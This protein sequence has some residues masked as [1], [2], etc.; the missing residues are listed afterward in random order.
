MVFNVEKCKVM[1]FGRNNAEFNYY[2][3]GKALE[4]VTEEKDLG[5]FLSDDLKSS[6]QCMYAYS[7]ASRMLDMVSRAITWK[8]P[9]I[10]LPFYKTLVRPHLEYCT[11]AWSPYYKKDKAL[12]ERVQ[13]RFTRMIPGLRDKVYR[14]RL[15][16]LGLWSLEERRNRTD[17][18]EV[19]KIWKGMSS[20]P[21]A[22]LFELNTGGNTRGHSAKLRKHHCRLDLRQRFFSERVISRWNRLDQQTIDSTSV[23]VFKNNLTRL[24]SSQMG[25]FMDD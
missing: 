5:I 7:R 20:V 18:I 8:S 25:L 24:R 11:A 4:K 3:D 14:E 22:D 23:N 10:L 21:F 13:H 9:K 6:R 19:F 17:L 1:H 15:R 16:M 12:L 2:M